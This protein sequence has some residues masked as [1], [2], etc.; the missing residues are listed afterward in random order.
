M[1]LRK[2]TPETRN[3]FIP[4]MFMITLLLL[5]LLI[6]CIQGQKDKTKQP[7]VFGASVVQATVDRIKDNCIFPNDFLFL[8]RLAVVESK[9]GKDSDTYRP[10]YHG[11]IWQVQTN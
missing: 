6:L 7:N 11:G 2:K 4:H 8:R 10:G 3:V 5:F 9:D 1:I